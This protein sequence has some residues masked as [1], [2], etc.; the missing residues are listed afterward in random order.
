MSGTLYIVPTPIG[1]LDDI[2]LRALKVLRQVACVAAEDTRS[3]QHLLRHHGIETPTVSYFDGNEAKRSAELIDRL[4]AGDDWALISE[5]GTPLI[6]DPGHRLVAR[7]IAEQIRVEV[8][9]GANAALTALVGSGLDVEAF[10][11]FGF[12][13]R[14]KGDR[15]FL[16]GQVAQL[17]GSLIFY[18]APTRTAATLDDLVTVLGAARRACVAR[19]LTKI[20]EE[21]RRGTLADLARSAH[22]TPPRGEVT[23]VV[24]GASETPAAVVDLETEVKRRLAAGERPN[25]IAAALAIIAGVP[26]RQIYQ[27]AIALKERPRS[28]P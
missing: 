10:H 22:Q 27:L 6:S 26:R 8:L 21:Y 12:L 24:S 4:L 19:E 13:P 14:P 17:S 20:Y 16:L 28:I 23:I 7:A 25:Q 11:F 18:E 15:Q 1:H 9:P 5:A 2:T 3:A